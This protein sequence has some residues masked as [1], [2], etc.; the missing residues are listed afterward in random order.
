MFGRAKI[1][2]EV[3]KELDLT[4]VT[5]LDLEI[6]KNLKKGDH[7]VRY[8]EWIP[9]THSTKPSLNGIYKVLSNSLPNKT[10]T[11]R[12]TQGRKE[13]FK[14]TYYRI[15]GM[16]LRGSESFEG[17]YEDYYCLPFSSKS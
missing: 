7:V 13:K 5:L 3:G 15:N 17:Y 8:T 1:K 11:F 16:V 9:P 12:D 6:I 2:I 10:I 14:K 4:K